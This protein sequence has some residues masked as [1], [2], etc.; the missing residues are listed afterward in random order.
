MGGAGESLLRW[1][2]SPVGFEFDV[3]QAGVLDGIEYAQPPPYSSIEYG[4]RGDSSDK[5]RKS[6]NE[7]E[8]TSVLY[9]LGK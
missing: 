9:G 3:K 5:T 2:A 4:G 1:A 8:W 6:A 7:G